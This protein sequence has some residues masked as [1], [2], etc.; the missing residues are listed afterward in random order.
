MSFPCIFDTGSLAKVPKVT[1]FRTRYTPGNESADGVLPLDTALCTRWP[2]DA[3]FAQY[4]AAA[5]RGLRLRKDSNVNGINF[6]LVAADLD[7]HCGI[8]R[9]SDYEDLLSAARNIQY[10]PNISYP[11]RAG[12]RWVWILL[13]QFSDPVLFE[14]HG[15]VFRDM[16]ADSV[17]FI[18]HV[19]QVDR[20]TNDWPR[21]FRCARVRRDGHDL[22]PEIHYLHRDLLDLA[23]VAPAPPPTL[24]P[25]APPAFPTV[26]A[27]DDR[28]TFIRRLI[29][30]IT[31]VSGDGG[32]AA[33]FF[34]ACLLARWFH[35]PRD[36]ASELLAEWNACCARPPW[37]AA[38]LEHK[39]RCAYR[40][41]RSE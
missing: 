18:T 2:T 24:P 29:F 25:V 39:L 33:T 37:S 12:C 19:Y 6:G 10:P 1:V 13:E 5:P 15:A 17:S 28:V 35:L 23:V 31:A 3:H 21:L 22:N 14:R 11:T 36:Q 27:T 41:K 16:V 32:D 30:G 34:V 8:S 20:R 4:S 26:A 9:S 7:A 38:A 40:N